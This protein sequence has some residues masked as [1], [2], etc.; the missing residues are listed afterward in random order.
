MHIPA[1]LRK[2]RQFEAARHRLDPIQD[3]EL[4]YW[5]VSSAGTALLNAALHTLGVLRENRH[6]ATQIPG[7]YAVADGGPR[8]WNYAIA[9]GGDLIHAGIP[10]L[11][12]VP[13]ELQAA[14]AA[15]DAIEQYRNPCIRGEHPV[16]PELVQGFEQAYASVRQ[17]T[18]AV[19]E[20]AFA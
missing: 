12:A 13:R 15:M 14:F 11:P 5:A 3:F 2:Y 19:L 20:E 10:A 4:W 9:S 17:V 18:G 6:F 1:H 8:G 7:V 16:T